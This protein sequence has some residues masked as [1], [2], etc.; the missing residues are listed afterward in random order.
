MYKFLTTINLKL[1]E[2]RWTEFLFCISRNLDNPTIDEIYIALEINLPDK[3]NFP[4]Q[5]QKSRLDHL[6]KLS[7]RIF[8][9]EVS[10]RPTFYDL[11][12]FCNKTKS[13]KWIICNSDIYFP[14]SNADKLAL[15]SK[16]DYK[17]ECF[18]L[19]RYNI[20]DEMKVKKEGIDIVYDDLNLRT[21]HGRNVLE[22][23]SIDSWIFE[24]PFKVNKNNFNIQLG[25]PG[26]DGMMNYQLSKIRKVTNPCLSII[27]IHK[28]L[29]W[30][31][32]YEN[33]K[34]NGRVMHIARYEGLMRKR[35]GHEKKKIKFSRL[36]E[37]NK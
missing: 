26:C 6:S 22:G 14:K 29:G 15:L 32:W 19:T 27:S 21:M 11:F 33:V 9:H 28:H 17:K 18:V 36:P 16:R 23:S 1:S 20:L 3:I 25:Q 4:D 10:W 35:W 13:S 37:D 5:E 2:Q 30:Y 31:P 24:T 8:I 7:K 34:F 12:E